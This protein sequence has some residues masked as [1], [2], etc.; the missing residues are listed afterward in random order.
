MILTEGYRVTGMVALAP[1]DSR[2]TDYILEAKDFIAVLEA[3]VRDLEGRLVLSAPFL[4]VQR[5][6][7]VVIV[8]RADVN[9]PLLE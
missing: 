2:L 3:E 1:G 5:A 7:V 4:N 6:Q 9:I 8:P